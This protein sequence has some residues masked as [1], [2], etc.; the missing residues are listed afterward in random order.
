MNKRWGDNAWKQYLYWYAADKKTFERINKLIK[1]I[2]RN[3]ISTGI[4]KPEKLKYDYAGYWSRRID[5]KIVLF[6][7]LTTT[8][9]C[10]LRN[11]K[12]ITNNFGDEK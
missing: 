9:I 3:G 11:V 12:D 8:D 7:R 1:D 4:G 10:I 6:I 2:E 5:E